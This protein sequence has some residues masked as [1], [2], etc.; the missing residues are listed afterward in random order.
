MIPCRRDHTAIEIDRWREPVHVAVGMRA[1]L[2]R[3]HETG[4]E[5]P[6][7]HVCQPSTAIWRRK[8]ARGHGEVRSKARQL[9]PGFNEGRQRPL[10][11]VIAA[12]RA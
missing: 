11:L 8:Q 7:R 3:G 10:F 5:E 4:P 1:K 12:F 6:Q 9:I 2:C